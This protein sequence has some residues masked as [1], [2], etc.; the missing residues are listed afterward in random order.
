M[1]AIRLGLQ[2]LAEV[3]QCGDWSLLNRPLASLL[4]SFYNQTN[5]LG[6][7]REIQAVLCPTCAVCAG[8]L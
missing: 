5:P 1:S 3:L 8:V 2:T 6:D 7:G 4:K